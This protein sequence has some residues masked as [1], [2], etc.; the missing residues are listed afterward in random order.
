MQRFRC[1]SMVV[2]DQAFSLSNVYRF[3]DEEIRSIQNGYFSP[4]K[5][6][7]FGSENYPWPLETSN[8]RGYYQHKDVSQYSSATWLV[9]RLEFLLHLLFGF[10]VMH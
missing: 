2:W 9:Q 5:P 4:G 10:L 3:G 7:C 1:A 8:S 6:P